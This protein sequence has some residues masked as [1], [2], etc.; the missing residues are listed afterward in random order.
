MSDNS[1]LT[2][3]IKQLNLLAGKYADESSSRLNSIIQTVQT[4]VPP[5]EFELLLKQILQ[6]LPDDPETELIAELERNRVNLIMEIQN[7][8]SAKK[9]LLEMIG[10]YEELVNALTA[11]STEFLNRTNDEAD[12]VTQLNEQRTAEAAEVDHALDFNLSR[13]ERALKQV[14]SDN[15]KLLTEI[16]KNLELASSAE[17]QENLLKLIERLN[18]SLNENI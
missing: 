13:I 4:I 15:T 16:Q 11:Y 17:Q 18:V 1:T 6:E 7:E 14:K 12:D 10:E 3:S 5:G 8:N 9:K 2:E